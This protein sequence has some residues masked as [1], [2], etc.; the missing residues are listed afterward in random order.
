MNDESN[1]TKRDDAILLSR[2]DSI[3][4]LTLNQPAVRNAFNE[5]MIDAVSAA[6]DQLGQD[7]SVRVIV[8]A[9][10]GPAFSA[11]ADLGWM[12]RMADYTDAENL[13]DAMRLAGMLRTIYSCPKP[14]IAKVQGDC[15]GGGVGLAAACDIVIAAE[16]VQFCLSEVKLGLIPATIS[17]YIIRALGEQAARRYFLTAERFSATEA[18]RLGFVHEVAS[19]DTLDATVATMTRALTAAGPRALNEAKRLIRDIAGQPLTDAL[20]AD[21][22]ERIAQ[23]RASDEGREGMRAFFDKRVPSWRA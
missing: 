6:F 14:V 4:T 23:C 13:A 17:P 8:M 20:V 21:T 19:A 16:S 22:A 10:N 1:Q 2:D 18:H 3:A 5:G 15:Y 9:A 11:G 12:K 7:P